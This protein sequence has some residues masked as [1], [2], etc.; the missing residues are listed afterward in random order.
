MRK[1][2]QDAFLRK[3]SPDAWYTPSIK[4]HSLEKLS[5]HNRYAGLFNKAMKNAWPQRAYIGLYSGAGR[6]KVD[7]TGEIIE[8]TAMSVFRLPEPFTHHIFVDKDPR[9]IEALRGRIGTLA[10]PPLVTFTQKDVEKAVPDIKAALPSFSPEKGLLSLCFI[11][12][13]SA[14]LDF[15]VIRELGAAFRVDF[16]ILLMSALDIRQNF[17]RYLEE[18]SDT[19]I[20]RLLDDPGWREDWAKK[21]VSTKD[22]V[23]F[24]LEKFDAAMTQLGYEA[25]N[26]GESKPVRVHGE[27]VLLYHLLFYSKHPL[28]KKLFRAARA[29]TDPQTTL[30]S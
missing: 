19:R 9:C 27:G 26:P 15:N 29:A 14:E 10:D 30:G 8:T 16:L 2:P 13:F 28:A 3:L 11:D 6:A 12:P 4:Q 23:H 21:G 24:I 7:P 17:Q 22:L 20:A 18:V 5:L 25:S 1:A